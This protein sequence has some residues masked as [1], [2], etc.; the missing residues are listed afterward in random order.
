MARKRF[1]IKKRWHR[2]PPAS[3]EDTGGPWGVWDTED[4]SY[5]NSKSYRKGDA[6]REMREQNR[7]HG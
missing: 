5:V 1:T 7:T 4:R 6:K 2:K 3:V